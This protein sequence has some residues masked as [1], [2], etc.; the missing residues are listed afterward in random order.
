M[1][2]RPYIRPVSPTRW[3]LAHPRYVRYMMRE[4]SSLFIGAYMLVLAAGL[5]RLGQGPEMY[6]EWLAWLRGPVGLGLT[7][8]TFLFTAYHTITWF[9]VTP[10]AMPLVVAG[11]RVPAAVIIGAH[12]AVFAMVSVVLWVL[13]AG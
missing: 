13:A 2:S 12:W 5:Y 9:Q 8:L 6:A 1:S 7:V 4:L 11:K 3:W 10:K